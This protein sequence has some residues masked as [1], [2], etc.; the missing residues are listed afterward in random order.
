M[1]Q[2]ICIIP[3]RI[4]SKRVPKKNIRDF[5]GR[6]LLAWTILQAKSCL[7]VEDV[8]VTTDSEDAAK[9]AEEYGAKPL[10]RESYIESLD[11]ASGGVPM[12]FAAKRIAK[13]RPLETILALF[14][15]SPLRK[16]GDLDRMCARYFDLLEEMDGKSEGLSVSFMSP[17]YETFIARRM[18]NQY[19]KSEITDKTFTYMDLC[20]GASISPASAYLSQVIELEDEK[21]WRDPVI[22]PKDET[23]RPYVPVEWWQCF[24]IDRQEDFDICEYFFG[25]Y[26]KDKWE[27]VCQGLLTKKK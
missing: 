9:I 8:Y 2:A 12:V 7:Y 19:F 18:D 23:L 13:T 16:P 27:E 5:H 15:T 24:E 22:F 14:A 1:N 3:A 11:A 10:M 4:G 25:A 26:L 21:S 17:R 6:P 20:G